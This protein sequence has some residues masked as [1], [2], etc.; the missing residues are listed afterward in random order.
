MSTVHK[1]LT[2][3]VI[4]TTLGW[5]LDIRTL[6]MSNP[7]SK[8]PLAEKK[9]V[10]KAGGKMTIGKLSKKVE[11]LK[12]DEP[13]MDEE[14]WAAINSFFEENGLNSAQIQSYND[15][16]YHKI[17][18]A[19][20]HLRHL[21]IEE[22]GKCYK[23]EFGE[24]VFH[25]PQFTETDD[26]THKL[27]PME[28][29]WRNITY[30]SEIY[31]DVTITPP[32]GE[33]TLY[34]KVY[35][36][37]IPVMVKS[38]LCNVSGI[39]HDKEKLGR[40]SE[41][42]FDHGGYFV[43]AP[44]GDSAPGASAQRRVLVPQERSAPNRVFIFSNRKARP[45]YKTYAE[46]RSTSNG[47]HTTTSTVGYIGQKISCVLPWIDAT[48]IPL[49][50]VFRALGVNDEKEMALLCLGPHHDKDQK[51]LEILVP[52]LEY[53]Y[54]CDNQEAALHF[55]GRRGRKF[56]KEDDAEEAS[57]EQDELDDQE[58]EAFQKEKEE[59]EQAAAFKDR[60]DAVSYARHL[61]CAE[62]LPHLNKGIKNFA[63][64]SEEERDAVVSDVL[65][66]KSK[67][68]GYMVHKIIDVILGRGKRD[69]TGGTSAIASGNTDRDHYAQKI[70]MTTGALLAQQF[71]GAFRRMTTEVI[72]NTRKA[73]RAGHTV[74]IT[75]WIKPNLIT[76]AM[77]GAI[78]TNAWNTGGAASKGISQLYE[79]FNFT[80]G[81]AN[82]RKL[83]VPMAA[84]G[85][86]SI[87]PRD[88]HQCHIFV[89]CPA[90]TP[91]GRN[92]GLVKNLAMTCYI[93][94]D[95][96]PA[97]VLTFVVG[98]L[99]DKATKAYP[100]SL[101]WTKVFLNG[102]IIGET[103]TPQEFVREMIK[104]RRH[105]EINSQTSV[106]YFARSK[107]IYISTEAGRLCR[108]V[109]VVED[110]ELTFK[111]STVKELL[112]HS[113]TWTELLATGK[114][115]LIDKCEEESANI[116]GYPSDFEKMN[117]ETKLR[118]T[119]CEFHPS[120]MFGIGGSIIPFPD[121]N[122]C[123]H[124]DE[125][126]YMVGG[127]TKK[128]RDVRVGDCVINFNPKTKI[129]GVS[130]VISVLSKPTTKQ[131]YELTTVSGRK[132]SATYDHRFITPS[133]WKMVDSMAEG[134]LIGVSLEQKPISHNPADGIVLDEAEFKEMCES[135]G[136]NSIE[137]YVVEL[138]QKGM[139]PLNNTDPKVYILSRLFGFS[140]TDCWI[141]VT[142]GVARLQADFG[143]KS[144]LM[145]FEDDLVGLG[146]ERAEGVYTEKEGYGDTWKVCHS[147]CLVSLLLALGRA[148]GKKTIT[149][150]PRV[151]GWIVNGTSLIQREFL[152]GFQGGDGCR[153]RWNRC[154]GQMGFVIAETM[155]TA[156]PDYETELMTMMGQIV[157]MIKGL[158]IAVD[159]P[160]SR[161]AKEPQRVA[162]SYKISNAQENLIKYFDTIGYRYDD[163]KVEA[164]GLSV[165]Y[166][167][168]LCVLRDQRREDYDN[169]MRLY[170]DGV[171]PANISK[172]L[173]LDIL[174][175]RKLQKLTGKTQQ[176]PRL[177]DEQT[178]ESWVKKV[179]VLGDM[180]FVPLLAKRPVS[181][182]K[183][184]D[185]TTDSPNQSFVC[186]DGFGVH[187]SPRNTY[188][189]LWKE[190]PVLMG[191]GEWKT[192]KDVKIGDE[193][194]SFNPENLELA[195]TRVVFSQVSKTEKRIVRIETAHGFT[196]VVTEDHK[197]MTTNG[198]K[199]AGKLIKDTRDT[200]SPLLL[201]RY[202][203]DHYLRAVQSSNLGGDMVAVYH[204]AQRRIVFD[205]I[206]SILNYK[207]VEI[208]DITTESDNHSFIGGSGI[209]VHNSAMGKQAVGIPF[210][211]YR[212]MMTGTFHT[213]QYL[214]KPLALSRAAS[215]IGFD[216]MPAGQNAIVAVIPR[217]FNEEDS[218]EIN[219]DSIDRG[220][221][222][223]YK[224]TGYYAE[225]S[226]EK[227]EFFG[228]PTEEG[229]LKFRGNS[230]KLCSDG[231]PKPGTK[232][233][234]G[235]IIIGK[236]A[237]PQDDDAT[238]KNVNKSLIYSHAWPSV[239]DSV[240]IGTT[241]DGYRYIRVMTCQ[242]REP[243][244]GD[245]FC[246]SPDHEVLTTTGWVSITSV[247]KEHLLAT[248]NHRGELEYQSPTEV[249][250]FDHTG[251]MVEV[252]TNQ[253]SLKVTPN[254]KMYVRRRDREEFKLELAEK[255][256]DVHVHYKKDAQWRHPGLKSFFLPQYWHSTSREDTLYPKLELP[257]EPW[258]TFFGI[259]IAEGCSQKGRLQIAVNKQRVKSKLGEVLEE[260]G[261]EY[262][263][264]RSQIL[265][266][267]DKQLANYMY[268]L[269]VGATNKALPEWTWE[270]NVSQSRILL[271]SM[272][273]GDGHMNGKTPMYD[274]SSVRLKD[275]IMR[276][277]LHCGWAANARVRSEKGTHK[278]IRGKDTVTTADAWRLTIVK[279]Q[280]E[281]AV[282]KH[283][284][285]QQKTIPYTG[286]VYCCTVPNH[287]IYVRRALIHSPIYQKPLWCGQ[288]AR[289]GQKGTVGSK[290][291]SV[292][293]PFARNGMVPDVV[294]NSLAYP[295][296]M[297]IA[298]LI[299]LWTGKAVCSS[300][301][302]HTISL[303]TMG[304]G[305][306]GMDADD[307]EPEEDE[308]WQKV[309]SD[310]FKAAFNHPK[311]PS[312]VDSTPFRK[313]FSVDI[314]RDE[315]R[316][317]GMEF[318]DEYMY[319]GVT[320]KL[321]KSLVFLAPGYYQRLKHMVIDK[322][323]ARSRGGRTTL[324][325]QPPEGRA[326][327]GG[328]RVGCMERDCILGQGAA[329]FSRDRLMEQS[330][331][332][333]HWVCDICGL[334]AHV[335][336][337]GEIKECRV[338]GT[339]KV[340]LIRIPYG[341]KLITQEMMAMNIV[342][343][344]LT[345][346]HSADV[347]EGGEK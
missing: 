243:V 75:S 336:K 341:T 269:S 226:E 107:E 23:V 68:L 172:M 342:P 211:N 324:C 86:K 80:A 63:D 221:M 301:P 162:I 83:S 160:V 29:L 262:V 101:G 316:K 62:F 50:V 67:F 214:Q 115:E 253:V 300:S 271:E 64:I 346:S 108:P 333:R 91:E 197:I 59:R 2:L 125:F 10:K 322:V 191:N 151:P 143:V 156:H 181:I 199:E 35:I 43:I 117:D 137:K 51:A 164:S 93:T 127:R 251:D 291:R 278:L 40:H 323:H 266:I 8:T 327:G 244:V 273:L 281:P 245:K 177:T 234:D 132:I 157:E 152:A 340:S 215:I 343:R 128:L 242:R 47:I 330:D 17:H 147:G 123:I 97:P 87:P 216:E 171:T 169:V 231:Y 96:D 46:I 74:N 338:C 237:S 230:S 210:T 190:E 213:L 325:R 286:K 105:N 283:I 170:Q 60:D 282:N 205:Y 11:A 33:A 135:W 185:I 240:Q 260:L 165:E 334:P 119:H 272:C 18:K 57:P 277:A 103:D 318:G 320:G 66:E 218:I 186:G 317:Y 284:K 267:H 229:C 27:Y 158:G 48:E 142:N 138:T 207:N 220:F 329:R 3:R 295:S 90:E 265:E 293:L 69:S 140:L 238:K 246:Y 321:L 202:S 122:Q 22:N 299:E 124:E 294:M 254:H 25:P 111:L 184:S 9:G 81:I 203:V 261:F 95:T 250:S 297:T 112:A 276:L 168:F 307:L 53:S 225:I 72:N 1:K 154:H 305:R 175:V 274:T 233:V 58:L 78:S 268:P 38:D 174:Y 222:V 298:M 61:L 241:G 5:P 144:S 217:P 204:H 155:K 34:E 275:D 193:V 148:P 263:I 194:L 311:D 256:F 167:R 100:E 98:L 296:R 118:Y 313:T 89:V 14:V 187:N 24:L 224:W 347:E 280:L 312:L 146:F 99:G 335:E 71:Y 30:A 106:A 179:K 319:D 264:G 257:I 239:V 195:K 139:L 279:T 109:F 247:T 339:N 337:Q 39:S 344:T 113:L 287:V 219:Q 302:L 292:D 200:I 42:I 304:L 88:L 192:I 303:A 94:V 306:D 235:D 182:K 12:D 332:F 212:Q 49:G 206:V 79:Q 104:L 249:V 120:L 130:K 310:S 331:E 65:A 19:I 56:M 208:A 44:K 236:M 4:K 84:E 183:I 345:I 32:T 289:H 110:G 198:W 28:A 82:M 85:G 92:T 314:I 209:C 77:H 116:A 55:I 73:L 36:G 129:S 315:M 52:T 31:V 159:E 121:H 180:I 196:I 134:D 173:N 145:K 76:N 290:P 326:A 41:D 227:N 133:G 176:L 136:V 248:L 16:I 201:E 252:E 259:W 163:G 223:S 285:G 21:K 114:V 6:G 13:I 258:L 141:G 37:N 178:I 288:S 45:K 149:P 228:I 126:V 166:L 270:L 15:L 7:S 328:L 54:E 308:G 26:S 189:C 131:L 20:E 309:A 188:Q 150:Y 255:L 70:V 102:V 153:I 232:V 161:P